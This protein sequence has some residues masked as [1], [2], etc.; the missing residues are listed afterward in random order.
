M[1]M[2]DAHAAA[3][4]DVE[5]RAALVRLLSN[6]GV[7]A[8]ADAFVVK[9]KTASSGQLIY[10]VVA[11]PGVGKILDCV[12]T[13]ATGVDSYLPCGIA[14]LTEAG[15]SRVVHAA[16]SLHCAPSKH[17][18]VISAAVGDTHPLRFETDEPEPH[19]TPPAPS[20]SDCVSNDRVPHGGLG[21]ARSHRQEAHRN[22]AAS[23][24]VRKR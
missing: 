17:V 19:A 20:S 3:P 14:V 22:S 1:N 9:T 18:Q 13:S 5:L 4:N 6:E 23:T 24:S 21:W 10:V 2:D 16:A 12:L 8:A 7:A 11:A 15:L